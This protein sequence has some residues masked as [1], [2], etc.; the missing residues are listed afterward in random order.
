MRSTQAPP[1]CRST[2][3]SLHRIKQQL[4]LINL[5]TRFFPKNQSSTTS[6]CTACV[7]SPS[8]SKKIASQ[9]PV[10][11]PPP[12]LHLVSHISSL[13]MDLLQ[14]REE[15]AFYF[16]KPAVG[17]SLSFSLWSCES[18]AL[19]VLHPYTQYV[20]IQIRLRWFSL[21]SLHSKL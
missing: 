9:A 4:V 14:A 18:S 19:L 10:L 20:K 2:G 1:S 17:A 12:S 15:H 7:F 6:S 8:Q 16:C 11:L 13:S 3:S 5:P 21:Y